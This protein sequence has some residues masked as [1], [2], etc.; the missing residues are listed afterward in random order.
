VYSFEALSQLPGLF[1]LEDALK[2][3][4]TQYEESMNTVL[5]QEMQ[6]FNRLLKVIQDSL[7]DLRKA[8]KG[9]YTFLLGDV[10]I[11][12]TFH[13]PRVDVSSFRRDG[14]QLEHWPSA[15]GTSS[16]SLALCPQ[17]FDA[18]CYRCG[19]SIRILA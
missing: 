11:H 1:D 17:L 6:R 9:W 15:R 3:Y 16:C 7:L 12:S 19:W 10:W 2:K 18:G 8:I 14:A 4:P 13:R 5:V